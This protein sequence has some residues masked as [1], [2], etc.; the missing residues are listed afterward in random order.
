VS[1]NPSATSGNVNDTFSPV[2]VK[3]FF[4]TLFLGLLSLVMLV[5]L[6]RSES[7]NRSLLRELRGD[8][9]AHPKKPV[10]KR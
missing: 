9:V 10:F 7:R 4:G 6:L 8:S 1:E 5:A 2:T 3:E